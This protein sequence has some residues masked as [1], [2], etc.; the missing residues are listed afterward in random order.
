MTGA[1]IF[2]AIFG[3]LGSLLLALQVRASGF[4]FLCYAFSNVCWIAF[5]IA[6]QHWGVLGM[7]CVFLLLSCVGFARWMALE[8]KRGRLYTLCRR[9]WWE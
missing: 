2:G 4:G 3:V 6:G 7:N 5:G 1:E 9:G 8:E